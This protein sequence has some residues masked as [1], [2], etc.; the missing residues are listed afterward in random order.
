[1]SRVFPVSLAWAHACTPRAFETLRLSWAKKRG[2]LHAP[3]N[4][5]TNNREMKTNKRNISVVVYTRI[6]SKKA[7][8]EGKNVC[9][10]LA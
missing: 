7:E 9:S 5:Q 8:V 3:Q 10:R 4:K 1:M 6:I 2:I